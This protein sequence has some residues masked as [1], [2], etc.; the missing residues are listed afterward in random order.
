MPRIAEPTE[1]TPFAIVITNYMWNRRP[2][3]RRPLTTSQLAAR[4]GVPRQSVNNWVYKGNVPTIE[5]VLAILAQLDIPLRE[6]YDAYRNAGIAVPRWD[7]SDPN[8]P[9]IHG[10]HVVD[11]R[12][13][14]TTGPIPQDEDDA[15]APRP[16]TPQPRQS[17]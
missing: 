6:L 9:I 10:A 4:L 8:A 7:E 12:G 3:N 15:P 14:Q 17:P 1:L 13:K 5:A 16:Y 11:R 2:P